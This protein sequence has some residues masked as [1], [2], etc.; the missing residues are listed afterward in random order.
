MDINLAARYLEEG[1][2]VAIPT[3]TVYGL[4]ANAFDENAVRKIYKAKNRPLS[5]PLI[6][7]CKNLAAVKEIVS[8]FPPAALLLAE[9]FWPGPLTLLLPKNELISSL[10]T[11]GSDLVAVRIPNHPLTLELLHLLDFPLAAPSANPFGYISPTTAAHVA[12]QLQGQVAYILDGGPCAV[13][14]ESTIVGFEQGRPRIFRQGGIPEEL[15]GEVIKEGTPSY[16]G[17]GM[18]KSHYA[19]R[20]KLVL[21]SLSALQ[22]EYASHKVAI[23]S[24]QD[25]YPIPSF[26]LSPQGSLE[27]AARN[28]FKGL[29]LLDK[30]DVDLILAEE[31]PDFGLGRAIN[32]RLRKA[33][34]HKDT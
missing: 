5:D 31:V 33:A 13:G 11:A 14:V 1:Q 26:V 15:I 6:V 32:E 8:E 30:E 28:L 4:A 24:F 18:L 3:E 16:Q 27:E 19:P 21:G 23:L 9:K 25:S 20:K 10:V 34:C 12:D 29:R 17:P 2:L 22:T 7:H